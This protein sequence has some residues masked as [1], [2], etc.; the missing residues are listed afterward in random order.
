M[1]RGIVRISIPAWL[2]RAPSYGTAKPDRATSDLALSYRL[3]SL[4]KAGMRLAAGTT[5]TN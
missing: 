1:V 2:A 3:G 5:Y 4:A